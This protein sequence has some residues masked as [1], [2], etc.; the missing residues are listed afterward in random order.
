MSNKEISH[1]T[2]KRNLQMQ[3]C[4]VLHLEVCRIDFFENS[5]CV[6]NRKFLSP[7]KGWRF[8]WYGVL[9][10]PVVVKNFLSWRHRQLFFNRDFRFDYSGDY[11]TV[12]CKIVDFLVNSVS[13]K[14]VKET[15]R[16]P[17]RDELNISDKSTDKH[18]YF[19]WQKQ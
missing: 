6:D 11:N 12:L 14:V 9:L 10:H 16:W 5:F 1:Y 17:K 19:E 7:M 8:C 2:D 15:K 4:F 13:W 18:V 3:T